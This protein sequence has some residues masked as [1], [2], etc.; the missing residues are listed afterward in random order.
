[1]SV[2]GLDVTGNFLVQADVGKPVFTGKTASWRGRCDQGQRKVTNSSGSI[3]NRPLV[4]SPIGPDATGLAH[5]K[6]SQGPLG[7][8]HGHF[9][10]RTIG[11]SFPYICA[12]GWPIHA[13]VYSDGSC[14][15]HRLI[16]SA[17]HLGILV[18]ASIAS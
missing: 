12:S 7:A 11:C 17:E 10:A 3:C 8:I 13:F 14:V 4:G 5:V 1:M 6:A 15:S 16:I 2:L 18:V 9:R